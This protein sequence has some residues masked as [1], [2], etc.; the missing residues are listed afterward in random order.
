MIGFKNDTIASALYGLGIYKLSESKKQK[1][2]HE[3][4]F[5]QLDIV[6]RA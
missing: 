6:H 3:V 2:D 4:Y 5:A 1:K